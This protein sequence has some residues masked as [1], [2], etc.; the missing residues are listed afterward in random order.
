VVEDILAAPRRRAIL[1][2]LA[3]AEGGLVMDDLV[4]RVVDSEGSAGGE[5][6]ERVRANIYDDHLPKLT[7]TG[8]V[9]YD[10]MR[11]CIEL[12]TPAI[13]DHIED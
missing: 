10:S 12:A 8:V 7:A 3:D 9:T 1:E 6:H 11:D 13:V 5:Q 2:S 4:R